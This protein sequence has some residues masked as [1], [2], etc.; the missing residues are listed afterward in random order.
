MKLSAMLGMHDGSLKKTP[1]EYSG[2]DDLH[3]HLNPDQDTEKVIVLEALT[4]V[5][6]TG[7]GEVKALDNV[8]LTVNPAEFLSIM[9]P[10]GSGKS[11]LMS[12]LGCLDIPTSG[13][14]ILQGKEVSRLGPEQLADIRNRNIGFVFQGYNLLQKMDAIE[15]VELPLVYARMGSTQSRA[16]ALEAL[17]IVGLGDRAHHLPSQLSG[18]EQQRVA[19]AR[20]LINQPDIILADEPTGNLDTANGRE[21]MY[22]FAKLNRERNLTVIIVTHDHEVAGFTRRRVTLQDGK[23]QKDEALS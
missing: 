3:T 19:I 1:D 11:T 8:S 22:L 18:G 5:Y 16:A 4:K 7:A 21:I 10:S 14:Y 17:E 15:N 13:K 2:Q 23:I 20:A 12:I 9:G 6:I